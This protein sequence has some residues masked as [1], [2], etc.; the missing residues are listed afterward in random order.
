MVTGL[1][2][3]VV[4]TTRCGRVNPG[5]NPGLDIFDW[6]LFDLGEKHEN[7]VTQDRTKDL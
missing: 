6:R 3:L 7:A 1:N 2:R 5:S 4:R